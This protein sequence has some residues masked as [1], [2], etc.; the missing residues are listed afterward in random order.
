MAK[1]PNTVV[2]L[3]I[4]TELEENK[5]VINGKWQVSSLELHSFA[6]AVKIFAY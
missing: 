1:Q 5:K 2:A 3:T 4:F 6:A